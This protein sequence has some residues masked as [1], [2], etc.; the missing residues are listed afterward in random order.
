MGLTASRPRPLLD[1]SREVVVLCGVIEACS[2]I[3]DTHRTRE[4]TV[5]LS[6]WCDA[7]PDLVLF[8]GDCLVHR[9]EVMQLAGDWQD[10]AEEAERSSQLLVGRPMLGEALFRTAEL[11]RLRGDSVQAD[12][13]YRAASLVGREPQPG[14]ALLRL[15]QGQTKA[16]VLAIRRAAGEAVLASARV[17]LLDAYIEIMLA[18]GEVDS[19]AV[20]S[21]EPAPTPTITA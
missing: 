18:A 9:A 17:R 6:R 16:A 5:A 21:A 10:A 19:A 14:L 4:W 20:A 3:L 1:T 7:Q 2:A 13:G 11:H 15:S 8:Q 12:E